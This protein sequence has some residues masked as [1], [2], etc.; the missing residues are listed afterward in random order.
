LGVGD[1]EDQSSRLAQ[2]KRYQDLILTN[3]LLTH[4]YDPSSVRG[5]G[6]RITFL[7]QLWGKMRDAIGKTAKVKKGK[8]VTHVVKCRP[9]RYKALNSNPSYKQPYTQ[10]EREIDFILYSLF[11]PSRV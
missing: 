3:K 5:I 9:R 7:N 11:E 1:Q 4:A 2:A 10:R 6:R 8:D